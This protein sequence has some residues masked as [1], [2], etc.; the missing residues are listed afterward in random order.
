MVIFLCEILIWVLSSDESI[1]N[2]RILVFQL[3]VYIYTYIIGK[4][5]MAPGE[6]HET[7]GLAVYGVDAKNYSNTHALYHA[8]HF[9]Q[10]LNYNM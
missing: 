7:R 10:R 6:V 9:E 5:E 1:K 3:E 4:Q 2:E 8:R